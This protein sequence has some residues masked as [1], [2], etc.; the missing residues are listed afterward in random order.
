[1]QHRPL[2]EVCLV[3]T[4]GSH[5]SPSTIGS[6]LPYVTVRD[7]RDGLI[8]TKSCAKI[9]TED[10]D[11]LSKNGCQPILGDVLFSK[12]GT[13]GKVA[14]VDEDIQFVVLSSIAI[15][16]PNPACAANT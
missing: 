2:S 5:F 11:K 9:S 13:V 16:R 12:D 1:M 4:D 6:G 3:I 14:V 7:L 15:L 8:D 10:F